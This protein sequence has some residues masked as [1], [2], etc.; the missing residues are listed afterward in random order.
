[1]IEKEYYFEM[2]PERFHEEDENHQ[3]P[4]ALTSDVADVSVGSSRYDKAIFLFGPLYFPVIP[5]FLFPD[6]EEREKERS[7]E[8]EIDIQIWSNTENVKWELSDTKVFSYNTLL[9]GIIT[10]A[11]ID[12][13]PKNFKYDNLYLKEDIFRKWDD[14]KKEYYFKL[15]KTKEGK[16]ILYRH[17]FIFYC[18]RDPMFFDELK[19]KLAPVYIDGKAYSFPELIGEKESRYE[20][21]M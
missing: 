9:F 14:E 20:W 11:D 21:K 3:F 1:M 4:N 15:K 8:I 10:Y 16:D 13:T 17:D 5:G 19:I 6:G 2:F 7:S 18:K 12:C